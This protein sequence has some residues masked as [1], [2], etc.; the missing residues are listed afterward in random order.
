MGRVRTMLIKKIAMRI[1]E[2]N[3]EKFSDDF[4]K[5]KEILKEILKVKSKKIRNKVAGYITK[6][7][8]LLKSS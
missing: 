2:E 6:I 8:K 1:F 4:E 5:N 7:V 3:K